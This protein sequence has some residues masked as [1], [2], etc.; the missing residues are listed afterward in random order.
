VPQLEH[1]AIRGPFR[2]VEAIC[3]TAEYGQEEERTTLEVFRSLEEPTRYRCTVWV[4][5]MFRCEPSGFTE[6]QRRGLGGLPD[7]TF[8]IDQ[9]PLR[10]AP[11]FDP[12]GYQANNDA[13]AVKMAFDAYC[14]CLDHSLGRCQPADNHIL[15]ECQGAPKV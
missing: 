10:M 4:Q 14:F 6:E 13:D 12:D 8:R 11:H 15:A 5:E 3:F 7:H 1:P 9:T 2:L